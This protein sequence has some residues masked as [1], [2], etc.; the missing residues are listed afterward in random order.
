M[1]KQAKNLDTDARKAKER[2]DALARE[3]TSIRDDLEGKLKEPA[4]FALRGIDVLIPSVQ[5]LD[6][7]NK[8]DPVSDETLA[9]IRR[10]KAE[11]A[12]VHTRF[13][14]LYEKSRALFERCTQVRFR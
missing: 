3:A 14:D 2:C 6:A 1:T 9:L 12:V 4:E 11:S 13:E 8:I 7:A 10:C 5:E